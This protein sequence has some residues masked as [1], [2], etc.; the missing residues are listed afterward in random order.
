MSSFEPFYNSVKVHSLVD[1]GE[2]V[3]RSAPGG[4]RAMWFSHT[5]RLDSQF[6]WDTYLQGKAIFESVLDLPGASWVLTLQPINSGMLK[7]SAR[8][9]GGPLGVPEREENLLCTCCG[10]PLISP[11]F[12]TVLLGSVFWGDSKDDVIMK[13][14]MAEHSAWIETTARN[15]GLL[16]LFV[17]MNYAFGNQ[18]VYDGLG[19]KRWLR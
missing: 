16:H 1:M 3:A 2:E 15:R 4:G 5:P 19:V 13:G 12:A 14:K 8:N 11:S 9:G 7:A 18:N 10:S 17:Y 6:P